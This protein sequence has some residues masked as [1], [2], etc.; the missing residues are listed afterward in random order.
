MIILL[1]GPDAYRRERKKKEIIEEFN[2]KHPALGIEYFDLA[3]EGGLDKLL[4]FIR[5]QSLF[6]QSKLA[7]A[8]NLFSLDKKS[9]NLDFGLLCKDKN[10]NLLI[11]EADL[12]ASFR[13]LIKKGVIYQKFDELKGLAWRRFIE[14]EAKKR[15]INLSPDAVHFLSLAYESDSWRLATEFDKLS[16]LRPKNI[17][18]SDLEK[19]NIEVPP[20]FWD[21]M[22]GFKNRDVSSR[23]KFLEIIFR[24]KEPAGKV[25]NILASMYKEKIPAFADYDLKVKSGKMDYEEAL[26]DL[27]ISQ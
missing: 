8:R 24:E 15:D 10:I 20:V 16:L 7:V 21:L 14:D 22:Y 2:K 4:G 18:R 23:L 9:L 5:G 13:F 25:F 26:V 12:P 27:A 19:F 11:S 17:K 3:E 1:Y 6:G